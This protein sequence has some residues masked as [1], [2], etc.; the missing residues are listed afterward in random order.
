[1]TITALPEVDVSRLAGVPFRLDGK[2][3]QVEET[4]SGDLLLSGYVNTW[5]EDRDHEVFIKAAFENATDVYMLN[6]V[7]CYE[8]DRKKIIGHMAESPTLDETGV[9]AKALITKPV[10]NA[11]S[12]RHQV[13]DDIKRGVL[14]AFSVGGIFYKDLKS[15]PRAI[16]GMDWFETSVVGVP[17]NP[18]SVGAVAS[19]K[20]LD[21]RDTEPFSLRLWLDDKALSAVAAPGVG[22]GHGAHRAAAS[23]RATRPTRAARRRGRKAMT[24]D[25]LIVALGAAVKDIEANS[26]MTD[27][28]KAG[29]ISSLA[30][31]FEDEV[32]DLLGQE[33]DESKDEEGEDD[34]EKNNGSSTDSGKGLSSSATSYTERRVMAPKNSGTSTAA[35]P[36]TSESEGNEATTVVIDS[37]ALKSMQEQLADL[38]AK[39]LER[40]MEV[41]AELKAAKILE[42]EKAASEAKAAR[43]AE[44]ELEL[45][46]RVTA[47]VE[48][49]RQAQ[50]TG[51]R[52]QWPVSA[53]AGAA[54]KSATGGRSLVDWLVDLKS[55][56]TGDYEAYQRLQVEQKAAIGDLGL[57]AMGESVNSTGGFLVPPQYWQQGLAE[58]RIAAAK[59]R[60]L[61]TTIQG[62]N[63]NLVFIPRET[64]ISAVGWVAEN[65]A[66]PATDQTFGQI[67]VPIFVLAGISKVPNQLL[68]DSS[69]AVDQIV[70]LDLGRETGQAEDIAMLAGTGNGQPTGILNTTGVL[71]VAYVAG[72][73]GIADAIN[74]AI[75]AV[76]SNYFGDPSAVMAH[77]R[78]AG[79]ARGA[80]DSQGR[81]IFTPNFTM[82]MA[83]Q[84]G[85]EPAFL[86]GAS[87]QPGPVG[88][89]WGLPL[90]SDANVPTNYSGTTQGAG[91]ES[92]IIVGKF[93]EAWLFERS[94]F[95]MDVSN[96][97]GTSF[98]S[99]QTWFRGEERLGFTAAR[100]PAAFC[101]ITGLNPSI[102]G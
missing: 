33:D 36:Q 54:G 20:G 86:G 1:M 58:F 6:P 87:Q 15:Y 85:A 48:R 91:N 49:A 9:H 27:E 74:A 64:G 94:G 17:S 23:R 45:N 53:G 83:V 95:V 70:R 100:Q 79:V 101:Y 37:K 60:P 55:A 78:N 51:R 56:R 30:D 52:M 8:H 89:I 10:A 35:D 38:T 71:T 21:F 3:L 28:E 16:L 65:A 24:V 47:A 75:V 98:E 77:P 14:R 7:I 59:V 93:D 29:A 73:S 57:K 99:N 34:E 69:P 97:A 90:I 13:F 63:S 12:W 50:T 80:K 19:A 62:I 32:E 41:E 22:R 88:T 67:S 26:D 11:P 43:E 96:E 72:N 81:Y 76:Q 61:V 18:F 4:P 40:S 5:A 2:N 25:T 68:E 44:Q 42:E 84:S 92:P 102:T 31:D 66:K 39:E 46:K 82:P